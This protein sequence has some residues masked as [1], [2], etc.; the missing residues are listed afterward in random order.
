MSLPT[1][2]LIIVQN[3]VRLQYFSTANEANIEPLLL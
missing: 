1:D 3:D 2:S